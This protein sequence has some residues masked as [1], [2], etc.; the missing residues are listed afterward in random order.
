MT[1]RTNDEEPDGS[2]SSE[3]DLEFEK[4]LWEAADGLRGSV[5]AAQY[6]HLV[7][8]L[9]FLKYLSDAF[10]T[11]RAWLD[12]Q[13]RTNG[14]DYFAT[15][16]SVRADILEDR[17]EYVS[18]NVFWVPEKARWQALVDASSQKDIGSRIDAA[19]ES[20]EQENPEQL[21]GALPQIY[22]AAPIDATSL[23]QLVLTLSK[24][25]FATDP[26][27]N[28]AGRRDLL[29]RVYEYFIKMFAR[30]E[31]QRGGEFYTPASVTRLLVEMLEPYK[32]RVYEPCFGSA[33][34]FVQSASFI[35]VHGG[36]LRDISLYGQENN[37][38]TWRIGRMNL[39]IH[40][41]TGD[42]KLG[43]TLLDDQHKSLKAD[44][45]IANPPF[46]L[47]KWGAAQVAED[48]RWKFGAPPDRNANYAWIQHIIGK[49]S[50]DGRAGF[51][52]ANGSLSAGGAEGKIR[53]AIIED[54]VVDC[55]VALPGQLFYTTQIPVC[56]WFLD[57]DKKS[58]NE[59]DRT[60]K[61]LF[62]DA[63]KLGTKIS[64]TQ[65]ELTEDE[66]A[67]ITGTYHAWRSGKEYADVAGFCHEAT[68]EE[69]SKHGYALTPGRFVGAEEIEDDGEPFE[70]KLPRLVALF[71]EQVAEGQRL[72]AEI[73]RNLKEL[74]FGG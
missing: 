45:V 30:S 71:N 18:E 32:G 15:D 7:L 56:L 10:E 46:N 57:R 48:S 62:I 16:D 31:G 37:Q 35:E 39:V 72:D 74:G 63:R 47:D 9:L 8:G 40:G 24:L 4:T 43:N 25:D 65:I 49:L 41:L 68:I 14:S 34:L 21:R 69:I 64:R 42:L 3:E 22:A 51:V 53:Q 17:D 11:R 2:G 20:I 60:G 36:R 19:L 26:S 5:E 58:A 70:E 61:V 59:N 73:R 23:G 6:K 13:T 28:G 38:A 66:L 12:L 33:G 67:R 29:G 1:A 27:K 54:D 44:F 55:I 52:L 50:P